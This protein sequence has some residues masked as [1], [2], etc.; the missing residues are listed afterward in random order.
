VKAGTRLRAAPDAAARSVTVVDADMTLPAEARCGE[1]AEV[2]WGGFRA[3]VRAGDVDGPSL[4][5]T[6]VPADAA[7]L[8][9]ARNAMRPLGHEARLGPWRVLTDAAGGE[10]IGLDAVAAH[11]AETYAA[12]YGLA[13]EAGPGQAVAIFASDTR[14]RAFAEADGSPLLK[15]RGHAGAG[16]AAFSLGRN[17]LETRVVFVHEVTHLLS[18]NALGDAVPVWLDEGMAE[19]LAWCRTD[20]DGRLVPD[21]LDVHESPRGVPTNAVERSGPRVT[22]DAWIARARIGHVAPLSALLT[23]GSRLL[24]DP[25]SRRDA[26]TQCAI[27][28][29]YGLAAPERARRFREF[30][31]A[32]SLGGPAN[33]QAL[34]EALETDEQTLS[35]EFL[36]WV[37]TGAAAR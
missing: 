5:R 30:L 32:V 26:A 27:L 19:D 16:L 22:A 10:L 29:R 28:V 3:W 18:R 8:A 4:E 7:R 37:R 14:Y 35:K 34:A 2:R 33:A 31:R 24:T 12:R 6:P 1:W 9:R 20:A 11:L 23:P 25:S 17:P 15:T 36:A 21:T 13:T